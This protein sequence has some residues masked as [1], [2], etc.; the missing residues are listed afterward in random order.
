MTDLVN[1][2]NAFFYYLI[3][4]DTGGF[5]FVQKNCN[6]VNG[7]DVRPLLFHCCLCRPGRDINH[8]HG[9][10]RGFSF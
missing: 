1:C 3:H 2:H 7:P 9:E 8:N 5:Y 10:L 6:I 4:N